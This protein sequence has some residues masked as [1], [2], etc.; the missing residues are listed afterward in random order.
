MPGLQRHEVP[1]GTKVFTD[2]TEEWEI[3]DAYIEDEQGQRIVDFKQH[4]LHV[5]GYSAPVDEWFDLAELDKHLYSPQ[6]PD[7]IP[8]VTSY[9]ARR[10]GFA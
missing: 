6:Q 2:S 1:T 4:N 3:R 9:Y 5:I 10:W 8:Y 7:A